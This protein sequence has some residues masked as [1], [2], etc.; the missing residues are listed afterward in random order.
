MI[1]NGLDNSSIIIDYEE[2]LRR[3]GKKESTINVYV[4]CIK[5]F[6]KNG[7]DL[8]DYRY[9][10]KFLEDYTI[11]KRSGHYFDILISFV[12]WYFQQDKK[13]IREL[14]IDAIRMTG[15]NTKDPIRQSTMLTED[16][17]MFII[18]NLEE[19]KHSIISW[20]QKE[21]GV[22]AGDVIRLKKDR[23]KF[24]YYK[25]SDGK[26]YLTLDFSFIKKGDKVSKIPVFN[27]Y[28]IKYLKELINN[29]PSYEE[30]L[31]INRDVVNKEN[32]NND[33]MLNRRN[34]YLYWRDLNKTCQNI[35]LDPSKFSTHDWRRNFADKVWVDVLGKTDIEAL[36]RALG[37]ERVETTIRYLRHS[38]LQSQDIFKRKFELNK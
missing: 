22:R 37:H 18:K 11:K 31:F 38:G 32:Q 14:I 20:I 9:Y 34:Y 16:Q 15:K 4:S 7:Y 10:N 24:G 33:F 1:E 6:L 27:P 35:G 3:R 13:A 30:Y 23:V 36:R 25:E 28:L 5:K 26:C 19:F 12:K 2:Y 21:T 17:Q 29:T 8:E